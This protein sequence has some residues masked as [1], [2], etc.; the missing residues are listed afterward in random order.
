MNLDKHSENFLSVFIRVH[1]WLESSQDC[2]ILG[3]CTADIVCKL[4]HSDEFEIAA[5]QNGASAPTCSDLFPFPESRD[6]V[7]GRSRS[8]SM[9]STQRLGAARAATQKRINHG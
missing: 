1:P 3:Y 7:P 2:T 8:L 5:M 6:T 4:W 9:P